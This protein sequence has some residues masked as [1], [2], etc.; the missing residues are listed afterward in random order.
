MAD[1]NVGAD[2]GMSA[3]IDKA[4]HGLDAIEQAE[5]KR[6]EFEGDIDFLF[7]SVI[8]NCA[9]SFDSPAPLRLRGNHFALPKIFSENEEDVA[10]APGAGEIDKLFGAFDVKLANGFGEVSQAERT[11]RER[12]NG[13][14]EFLTSPGDEGCFLLGDADGF[15]VDVH[16]IKADT[17][18]MFEAGDGIDPAW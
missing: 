2:A 3:V 16:T 8:A 11:E 1:V 9:A 15:G 6:L 5:P 12:N 4:G 7:L 14:A 10:G 13:Q 17:G 18:D